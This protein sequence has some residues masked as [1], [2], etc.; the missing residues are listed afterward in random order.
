MVS[1]TKADNSVHGIDKGGRESRG[2]CECPELFGIIY[3]YIQ[4]FIGSST[5]PFLHL[6]AA[7]FNLFGGRFKS[8]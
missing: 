7:I 5:I 4:D 8:S 6:C 3:T 1:G 2:R